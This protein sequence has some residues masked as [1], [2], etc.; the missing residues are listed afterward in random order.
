MAHDRHEVEGRRPD[1]LP[2]N[3]IFGLLL[4]LPGRAATDMALIL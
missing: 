3:R 1:T 4:S 2:Q